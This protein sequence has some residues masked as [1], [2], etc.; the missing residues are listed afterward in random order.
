MS[1]MYS[2]YEGTHVTAYEGPNATGAVVGRGTLQGGGRCDRP[3]DGAL[4]GTWA[5]WFKFSLQLPAP[6]KSVFFTPAGRFPSFPFVDDMEFRLSPDTETPTMAPTDAPTDAPSSAPTD[7]PTDSPT[8]APTDS[9]T[10][11][12][13]DFPTSFPTSGPTNVPTD[14][15]T[16]TPTAAPTYSPTDLPTDAPTLSPTG[17][18]TIT[19][20]GA[21]IY[22]PTVGTNTH[23][24]S[25]AATGLPIRELTNNSVACLVH[26]YTI[27][28]RPAAAPPGGLPVSMRLVQVGGL[29]VGFVASPSTARSTL[30]PPTFSLVAAS[31]R[32]PVRAS[33][34]AHGRYELTSKAGGGT[35]VA[36]SQS[37]LACPKG[38][39]GMKGCMMMMKRARTK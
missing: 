28:V 22:S 9:P 17:F 16:N 30:M 18:P 29:G 15:P 20:T 36:F 1:F 8:D 26:P 6:A 5:K 24:I 2:D 27:E 19:S 23:W 32:A 12:P 3:C 11:T 4:G 38:A 31:R 37:C 34:R 33:V 10:D 35:T 39:K 13:T 7:A 14:S 25:N 21:P